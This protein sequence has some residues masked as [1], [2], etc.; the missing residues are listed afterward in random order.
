MIRSPREAMRLKINLMREASVDDDDVPFE[1]DDSRITSVIGENF[2]GQIT[3]KRSSTPLNI[4]RNSLT[5]SSVS[6]T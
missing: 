2:E 1:S 3:P 5:L 4:E 6:I